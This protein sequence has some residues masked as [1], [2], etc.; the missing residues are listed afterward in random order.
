[1]QIL[2]TKRSCGRVVEYKKHTHICSHVSV[3]S[4][5]GDAP[6]AASHF[7]DV[8]HVKDLEVHSREGQTALAYGE[9]ILDQNNDKWMRRQFMSLGES[10]CA[11]VRL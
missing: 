10:V 5:A 7:A 8:R 1:M 4:L 6:L 2:H 11:S 3:N 9:A